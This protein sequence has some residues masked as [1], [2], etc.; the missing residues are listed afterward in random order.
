MK[1]VN[2]TEL[3]KTREIN[4]H[5]NRLQQIDSYLWNAIKDLQH[6]TRLYNNENNDNLLLLEVSDLIIMRYDLNQ[7]LK[8]IDNA[9]NPF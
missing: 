4:M 6:A 2:V 3:L 1:N 8:K 9:V 5:I 7:L